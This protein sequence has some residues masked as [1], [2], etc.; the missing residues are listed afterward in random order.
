MEDLEKDFDILL[1]EG[2]LVWDLCQKP[3]DI[4]SMASVCHNAI[5]VATRTFRNDM[6]VQWQSYGGDLPYITLLSASDVQ[7]LNQRILAHSG[8]RVRTIIQKVM[9]DAFRHM[10]DK[11]GVSV[12]SEDLCVNV[13]GIYPHQ[14]FQVV[15][16][17]GEARLTC[18]WRRLHTER[19]LLHQDLLFLMHG[20]RLKQSQVWV[21]DHIDFARDVVRDHLRSF[22]PKDVIGV[23][24]SYLHDGRQINNK[25][26]DHP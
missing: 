1:P 14:Q 5:I 26:K 2:Q 6:T 11:Y 18:D 10:Y 12:L 13:I 23:V 9:W 8:S 20:I 22:L 15:R 21:P 3:I 25:R 4:R 19:T 7:A 17:W 16:L 24:W